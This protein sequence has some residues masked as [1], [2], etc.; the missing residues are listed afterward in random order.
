M[1]ASGDVHTPGSPQGK[2][3]S[4][5]SSRK[6]NR[7]G[8]TG[9]EQADGSLLLQEEGGEEEPVG[10]SAATEDTGSQ[11]PPQTVEGFELNLSDAF[12]L[13]KFQAELTVLSGKEKT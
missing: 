10:P 7:K 11:L 12:D 5:G 3:S 9:R 1:I 4:I 6:I 2:G 8:G 13:G